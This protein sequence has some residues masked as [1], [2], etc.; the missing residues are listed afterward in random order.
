M[1]ETLWKRDRMQLISAKKLLEEYQD[2]VDTFDLP[3]IDGVEQLAWGMKKIIGALQ[4]K[5]V[6]VAIDATCK[7]QSYNYKLAL[8]R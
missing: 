3:E 7:F 2:D 6:E 4:G 8:T 1:S 5:I